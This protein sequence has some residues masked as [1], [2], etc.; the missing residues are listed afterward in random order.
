MG[1]VTGKSLD[2]DIGKGKTLQSNNLS[3]DTSDGLRTIDKDSLGIKNVNDGAKLVAV[4]S[5]VDKAN[6]ANF[7]KSSESLKLKNNTI[8]R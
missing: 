3:V 5:I 2:A 4:R 1:S 6:A 7:D 8:Q